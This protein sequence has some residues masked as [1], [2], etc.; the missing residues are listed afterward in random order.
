MEG[1]S[2]QI[3]PQIDNVTHAKGINNLL[4]SKYKKLLNFVPSD[5]SVIS[6]IDEKITEDLRSYNS[7]GLTM[8]YT[9][10]MFLMFIYLCLLQQ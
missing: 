2:R 8:C 7:D 6:R 1:R 4:S 9:H 10:Q 3:P 5:A